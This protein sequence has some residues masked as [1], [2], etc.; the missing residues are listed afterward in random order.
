MISCCLM[1]LWHWCC[2]SYTGLVLVW[3]WS[4]VSPY[5]GPTLDICFL[6]ELSVGGLLLL[7][8]AVCWSIQPWPC[9]VR[10]FIMLYL[11]AMAWWLFHCRYKSVCVGFLYTLVFKLPS[12]LIVTIVSKKGMEPSLLLASLV[13]WILSIKGI[14]VFKKAVFLCLLDD[15]KCIIY[16]PGRM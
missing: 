1:Y 12:S 16:K 6:W 10:Y 13:N 5:S 2:S 15:N 14:Y 8:G 7:S 9:G 4:S 3:L 11:A